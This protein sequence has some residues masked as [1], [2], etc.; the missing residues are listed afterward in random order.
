MTSLDQMSYDIHETAVQKG[1]WDKDA[2]INFM[3]AKLA[4]IHS[5]I[6]E[7]LEAIR[8]QQG[9]E[10]IVEECVDVFIRLMD[11]YRGAVEN[12]WVNSSFDDILHKKM[13]INKKRNHMHG[14]LA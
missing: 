1:F 6:S 4:L 10:K 9:E 12:G 2:D 11:W 14:N 8:K 5:E 7:V 3:L 13:D